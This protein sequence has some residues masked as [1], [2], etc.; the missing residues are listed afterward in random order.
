MYENVPFVCIHH[1]EWNEQLRCAVC[2]NLPCVCSLR[3]V[4]EEPFIS[5]KRNEINSY[6]PNGILASQCAFVTICLSIFP[7]IWSTCVVYLHCAV[8][9]CFAHRDCR[10]RSLVWLCIWIF[11]VYVGGWSALYSDASLNKDNS[12]INSKNTA[13]NIDYKREFESWSM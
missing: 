11:T 5:V 3:R 6:P 10:T 8:N 12:A 4:C 9:R 7:F 1:S 13:N 2:G